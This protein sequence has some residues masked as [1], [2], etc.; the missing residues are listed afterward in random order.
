MPAS[1]DHFDTSTHFRHTI[2]TTARGERIVV[3]GVPHAERY[4]GEQ[5]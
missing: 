5:V 2:V 3:A 1:Q 4:R